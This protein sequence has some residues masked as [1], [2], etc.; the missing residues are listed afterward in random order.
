MSIKVIG[1]NTELVS[2]KAR[3]ISDGT[4]FTGRIG[5][6]PERLFMKVY[7]GGI[8][9]LDGFSPGTGSGFWNLNPDVN[10]YREVDIEIR[11]V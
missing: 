1:N 8:T 11:I 7:G 4:V 6:N 2:R 3:D 10:D 5:H 9:A